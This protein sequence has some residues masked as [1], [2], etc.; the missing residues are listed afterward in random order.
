[1]SKPGSEAGAATPQRHERAPRL[2]ESRHDAQLADDMLTVDVGG[3]PDGAYLVVPLAELVEQFRI[4]FS[5]TD[6]KGGKHRPQR[7]MARLLLVMQDLGYVH[8]PDHRGHIVAR[9]GE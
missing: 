3:M 2:R 1:M 5:D 4:A 8:R 6:V 9:G 7:A